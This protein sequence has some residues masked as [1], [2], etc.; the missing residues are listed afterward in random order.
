MGVG[1][2]GAVLEGCGGTGWCKNATVTEF[3]DPRDDGLDVIETFSIM[4][5]RPRYQVLRIIPSEDGAA[6]AFTKVMLVVVL[7][8]TTVY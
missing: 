3:S 7:L 2:R 8:T 5:Q 1:I 6:L 4:A